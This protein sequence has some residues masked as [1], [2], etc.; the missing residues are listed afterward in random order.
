MP[1]H[2]G[3]GLFSIDTAGREMFRVSSSEFRVLPNGS[4]TNSELGTRNS[5][6]SSLPLVFSLAQPL[7][8]AESSFLGVSNGERLELGG[9]AECGKD[10]TDRLL[11]G[12][13]MRQRLRGQRAVQRESATANGAA[14]F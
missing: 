10:F 7:E 14:S 1:N 4:Q 12:R 3:P 5:E 6:H 13:T 8:D 9:R 11:A 2:T